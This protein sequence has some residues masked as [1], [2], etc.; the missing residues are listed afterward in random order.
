MSIPAMHPAQVVSAADVDDLNVPWNQLDGE[1]DEVYDLFTR[2]YL[3]LGPSR[4]LLKAYLMFL[5]ETQPAKSEKYAVVGKA[6]ADP[7]WS[8]W[9]NGWNWRTRAQAFDSMQYTAAMATVQEA[10]RIILEN[11]A[12]A[13]QALVDKLDDPRLGVAAAKEL[14]DR[15][16]LPAASVVGHANLTP[17][18]T[19]D[20]NRASREL[21]EWQQNQTPA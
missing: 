15:G 4:T 13:A 21:E 6:S 20:F 9:A 7:K 17:F 19:D 12:R 16:G 2:F 11:V 8:L 3:P 18:T 1:P 5:A 10:R 14:L